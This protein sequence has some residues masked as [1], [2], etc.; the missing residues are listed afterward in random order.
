M[1]L[2]WREISIAYFQGTLKQKFENHFFKKMTVAY[3]GLITG[4]L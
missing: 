4:T 2:Y 1:F 3:V